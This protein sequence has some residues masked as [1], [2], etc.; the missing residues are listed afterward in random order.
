MKK[1]F[2]Y[3]RVSTDQQIDGSGLARQ[4]DTLHQYITQ[5]GIL[6]EMDNPEPVILSDQGVSAF[7]GLNFSQGELGQWMQEVRTGIWDGSVL[8]LESIDR[9]S[10]QNPFVVMGYLSD[11]SRH[12]VAI[13]DV[14][15]RT[16]ISN[17]NSMLLPMVLM[18]AQRAFDESKYK[19][20][21]IAAGWQ[22]RR[23]Q[24]LAQ[25]TVITNKTPQWI[26]VVNDQY[27]LNHK[28]VVIQEIFRLYQ[29]G[30]GTPSIAQFLQTKADDP[31]W[32]FNRPWTGEAVHKILTNQ[33]LT[34]TIFMTQLVRN[35]PEDQRGGEVLPD[36]VETAFE[37]E[38]YPVV[39]EKTEFELVQALLKSRR[40]EAGKGRTRTKDGVPHK[41]NLFSGIVRCVC[42]Q[43]MFHNIVRSYRE[44]AK[45]EP[46]TEEYR[47]LRCLIERD[48][49][50]DNKPLS[51]DVVEKFIVEHIRGLDLSYINGDQEH[52][53]EAELVRYQIQTE[54]QHIEEYEQGIAKQKAAGKK[55]SF[56]MLS[57]LEDARD[58]MV[59]LQVRSAGFEKVHVDLEF[60]KSMDLSEVF[61]VH[62]VEL[63]NRTENEISKILKK[64]IL[65]RT[66]RQYTIEIQYN[67]DS[68]HRH[69]LFIKEQKTK[70]YLISGILIETTETTTMYCTPSFV[71]IDQDSPRIQFTDEPLS[72]IDYSLLLNY[73]DFTDG[74][75]AVAIWMRYNQNF[76]F[77]VP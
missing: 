70:S 61:D 26:D 13:H 19:S 56:D 4:A 33:R 22:K 18:N 75:E 67:Q 76:L 11:L 55:V 57:E 64:V 20:K 5:T 14:M 43:A 72:L 65:R 9:F 15:A 66:G 17:A 25:G 2:I 6:G 54:A 71:I 49:L 16:V 46:F 45:G 62:N 74:S 3:H 39:I 31:Q 12:N 50:C 10:R 24:A 37:S 38:V 35:F 59:A 73:L 52:N 63:R 42:G 41:S 53:V 69:V 34:G 58:R 21:R 51:Y 28:A 30:M 1:C 47:Y 77:M 40:P 68:I 32:V 23:E 60:I 8:V 48:K 27:V 29:T 7:K 36:V 44:P